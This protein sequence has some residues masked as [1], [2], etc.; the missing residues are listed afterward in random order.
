VGILVNFVLVRI[1][2]KFEAFIQCGL[3][4]LMLIH[5]VNAHFVT[6]AFKHFLPVGLGFEAK[7]NDL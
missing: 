2:V 3:H 6:E 4:L 5:L 1:V 7:P